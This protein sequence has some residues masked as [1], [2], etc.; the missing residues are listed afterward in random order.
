MEF[1]EYIG[2]FSRRLDELEDLYKEKKLTLSYDSLS[3]KAKTDHEILYKSEK[4]RDASVLFLFSFSFFEQELEEQE[5]K[6]LI[7]QNHL[8]FKIHAAYQKLKKTQ[9]KVKVSDLLHEMHKKSKDS[10]EVN[11][12]LN[13]ILSLAYY[14]NWNLEKDSKDVEQDYYI[15]IPNTFLLRLKQRYNFD[16][17]APVYENDEFFVFL[18]ARGK[19]NLVFKTRDSFTKKE[20]EKLVLPFFKKVFDTEE[21]TVG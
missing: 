10:L 7:S 17:I 12:S 5:F 9:K 6:R 11:D 1:R 8:N 13:R 16:V 3:K 15:E 18:N 4:S 21:I 2:S 14:L 20:V 19:L